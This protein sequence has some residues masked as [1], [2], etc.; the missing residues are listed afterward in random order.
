MR[1][2]W[3][4]SAA[5]VDFRVVSAALAASV[6]RSSTCVAWPVSGLHKLKPGRVKVGLASPSHDS[7]LPNKQLCKQMQDSKHRAQPRKQGVA[8]HDAGL[9]GQGL[10]TEADPQVRR[11][12]QRSGNEGG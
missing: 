8:T 3:M 12:E 1:L 9:T 4:S 10:G 6:A 7:P 11:R 5:D 2:S